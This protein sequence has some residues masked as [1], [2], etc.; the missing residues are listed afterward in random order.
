MRRLSREDVTG[1]APDADP[2]HFSGRVR[3]LPVHAQPD[4]QPLRASVVSFQDGARTHWHSHSGGQV[5]HVIEG[6][7]QTQSRGGPVTDLHPGDMVVA[8]PGEEHWHGA[9]PGTAMQHLAISLGAV[10][11]LEPAGGERS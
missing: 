3:Q 4:P 8:E 2:S 9:A 1:A 5:L 10:D 11:W 6:R 7:G